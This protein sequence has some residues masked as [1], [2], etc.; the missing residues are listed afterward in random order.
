MPTLQF[1]DYT[2]DTISDGC[3]YFDAASIFPDVPPEE[4]EDACA[5]HGHD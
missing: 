1:G 3:L 4:L 5:K 2:L